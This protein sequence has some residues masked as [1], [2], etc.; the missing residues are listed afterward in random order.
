MPD[1]AVFISK[2]GFDRKLNNISNRGTLN[3][4]K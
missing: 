4:A 3:K 1:V 2:S